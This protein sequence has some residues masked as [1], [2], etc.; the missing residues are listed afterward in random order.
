MYADEEACRLAAETIE[1]VRT[2]KSLGRE[3]HFLAAFRSTFAGS[4][5]RKHLCQLHLQAYFYSLS[6]NIFYFVQL[7]AF[8][9]GFHLIKREE[10]STD[11]MFRIY[12]SITIAALKLGRVYAQLPEQRRSK[13][14]A[15]TAFRLI[16]RRS[17]I[18]PLNEADGVRPSTSSVA[19]EIR[20]DNVHFAYP[21]RPDAKILNGFSLSVKCGETHALVGPSGNKNTIYPCI[22][23]KL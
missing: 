14:A 5:R 6:N 8:A 16:E 18:D 10:I 20:F 4:G 1:S 3:Q 12:S 13:E 7:C 11:N 23:R 15:R 17:L 19:A 22:V 9:Y 21:T 2:V